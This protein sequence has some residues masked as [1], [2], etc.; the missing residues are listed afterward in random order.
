MLWSGPDVSLGSTRLTGDWG[1][2]LTAGTGTGAGFGTRSSP[3][4]SQS[5]RSREL[6]KKNKNKLFN[7]WK[8]LVEVAVVDLKS[9]FTK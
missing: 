7:G 3:N 2:T 8:V 1:R 6:T 9:P 5:F 4:F